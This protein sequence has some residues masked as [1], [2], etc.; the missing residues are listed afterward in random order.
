MKV[1]LIKKK[2]IEDFI[3]ANSGAR[4]GFINWLKILKSAEWGNTNDIL[5]SYTNADVLGNGTQR[6]VFDIGGNKYRCICE[7][8]FGQKYVHLFINWIGTHAEYTKICDKNNQY[9]I[10]IY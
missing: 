7:Y 3:L 2:T 10:S 4:T 5:K 9:I 1:H 8:S 6:I